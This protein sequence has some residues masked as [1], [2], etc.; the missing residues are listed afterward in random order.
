MVYKE[1]VTQTTPLEIVMT[2]IA[3]VFGLGALA[4]LVY[5]LLNADGKKA[6]LKEAQQRLKAEQQRYRELFER[7][8]RLQGLVGSIR[9]QVSRAKDV[10][11][12]SA[13]I[14]AELDLFDLKEAQANTTNTK[15]V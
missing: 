1:E 5:W 12:V 3:A 2:G 8:G 6:E 10:D 7:H 14:A 4:L 9:Q 15:E 11:A 13:A